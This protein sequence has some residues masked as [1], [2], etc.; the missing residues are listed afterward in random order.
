MEPEWFYRRDGQEAGPFSAEGIRELLLS[1]ELRAGQA[2]W[3][4]NEEEL[5]HVRADIVLTVEVD[6]G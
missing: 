6:H 2:I 3:R 5:S 1:G 4:R